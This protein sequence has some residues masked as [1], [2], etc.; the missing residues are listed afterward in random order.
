[1][2]YK[3]EYKNMK[4]KEEDKR[5]R[6]LTDKQR[7]EIKELYATGKYSQRGLA[8]KYNVTRNVIIY[9]IYPE[10]YKKAR[11]RYKEIQKTGRY[12]NRE[13]QRKYAQNYRKYKYDLYKKGKLLKES[14]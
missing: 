4:M 6:K 2:P 11:E 14:D 13:A 3:F 8:K 12:Y 9:C 7:K 1:M 10:K 5:N